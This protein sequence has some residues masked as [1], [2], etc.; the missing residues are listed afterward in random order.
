ML[1]KTFLVVFLAIIAV[2]IAKGDEN[3]INVALD[4]GSHILK[5][6]LKSVSD[7]GEKYALDFNSLYKKYEIDTKAEQAKSFLESQYKIGSGLTNEYFKKINVEGEENLKKSIA[8]VKKHDTVL[9]DKLYKFYE[10]SCESDRLAEEIFKYV[11]D[12][13][14]VNGALEK[15]KSSLSPLEDKIIDFIKKFEGIVLE[16]TPKKGKGHK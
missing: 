7:D 11:S 5:A 15:V 13:D 2:S 16:H 1:A 4:S 12:S 10:K 9:A 8:E 3:V 14:R 6:I